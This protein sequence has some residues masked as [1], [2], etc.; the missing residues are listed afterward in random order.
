MNTYESTDL[1]NYPVTD[2]GD[3]ISFAKS[4]GTITYCSINVVSCSIPER[5][6]EI[7][8]KEIGENAFSE[9]T[10]L[11]EI[12][13]PE[14]VTNIS[15]SAFAGC[16]ELKTIK[17]NGN[18]LQWKNV[19]QSINATEIFIEMSHSE[20]TIVIEGQAPT[21]TENGLTEGKCCAV[22]N[23]VMVKQDV[24]DAL[25]HTDGNECSVCGEVL[26]E[27]EVEVIEEKEDLVEEIEL[28]EENEETEYKNPFK[29]V[30]GTRYFYEPVLWA[31]RNKVTTGVKPDQFAPD[32]PCTRAQVVTFLWRA[33]G[34][35][36]ASKDCNF[37]DMR[38]GA[39]Y[40]EAV[41]WAVE[42]G[43]TTGTSPDK[44]SP[45]EVCTRAQIVSFL[46]RANG[47]EEI[48][49]MGFAIPLHILQA[50][51]SKFFK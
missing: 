8:V 25:G 5:I 10:S 4:T 39:Y 3:Y 20:E 38:E 50:R 26:Q 28:I 37:S 31:V 2:S 22:C 24:I 14:S 16:V 7:I 49:G 21:C 47:T 40:I 45:D 44:F 48:E 32:E 42:K 36:K 18:C 30:D 34:E 23:E 29:D 27:Q 15:D 6:D 1:I 9:C 33:A 19:E 43:I 35:P 17:Y 12:E 51:Y 46:W 13:I 41:K 11:T